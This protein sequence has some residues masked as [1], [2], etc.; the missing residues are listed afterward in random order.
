MEVTGVLEN[1]PHNT[2]FQRDI[3]LP[4]DFIQ[5]FGTNWD[6]WYNYNVQTFILTGNK[7]DKSKKRFW[8]VKIETRA[9]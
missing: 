4:I 1:I 9:I 3:F 8:T 5:Q 2:H 6:A 7:I